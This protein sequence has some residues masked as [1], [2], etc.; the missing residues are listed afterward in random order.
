MIRICVL[1]LMCMFF[2][3]VSSAQLNP[4]GASARTAQSVED[5]I[6]GIKPVKTSSTKDILIAAAQ[7]LFSPTSLQS[8][9]AAL[10]NIVPAMLTTNIKL[11]EAV[12]DWYGIRYR[13]GGTSKSG[14]DCSAFVRAV[15]E[16]AF[17][18]ELPR[19]AR[20]QYAAASHKVSEPKQGDLLFFNTRGGVSHV[21]VYLGNDRFAHASSSKG[22]MVSSLTE[23]YY[24]ARYLGARRV[25]N[26]DKEL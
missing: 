16:T 11:L 1:G 20:E 24:A 26:V 4:L 10:L 5:E 15:Y 18:I 2:V 19:T 23:K 25:D 17:G 9:Y 8:K 3:N 7:K 6:N 21:G 22:V 13:F 14:V 12:D